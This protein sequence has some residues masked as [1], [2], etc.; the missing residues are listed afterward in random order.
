MKTKQD[1]KMQI[2]NY[3]D[4]RCV[5][6]NPYPKEYRGTCDKYRWVRPGDSVIDIDR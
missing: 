3:L 1:S 5:Y 2:Y 4:V 6:D